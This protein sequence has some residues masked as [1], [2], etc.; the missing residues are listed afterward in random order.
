MSK[1]Q[2]K[3]YRLTDDRS[4]IS[5]DLQ[6]GR[7]GNLTVYDEDKKVRRAIRH[8]PNQTSIYVDKQDPYFIVS[9]IV[10]KFG[11]LTVPADQPI[12]Q[13]FLDNHPD[14]GRWFEEVNEEMEAKESIEYDELVTDVKYAIRETAK[15]EDGIHELSAVVAAITGS[16]K[17]ASSLGIESLKRILYNKVEE[18]PYRFVNEKGD[19]IMFED[20]EMKR[21]Y[22]VL[23]AIDDAIIKKSVNQKSILWVKEKKIITTAPASVDVIDYFADYL[24]T[25]E[26]RLVMEEI[27]KRS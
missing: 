14:K 4:G 9:P 26:G 24:T 23:R 17:D 11:Q 1:L 15:K 6:V 13:Q 19:V 16:V 5:F 25:D 8:C 22:I 20:D 21:R 10:F 3:S 7:K 18:N 12:T 27:V 2:S